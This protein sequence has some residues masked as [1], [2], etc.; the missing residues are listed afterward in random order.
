MALLGNM[1]D[2]MDLLTAWTKLVIP[3]EFLHED[4]VSAICG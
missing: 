3:S 4:L 1:L 2:L